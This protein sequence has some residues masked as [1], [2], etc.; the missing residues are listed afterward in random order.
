MSLIKNLSLQLSAAWLL[1]HMKRA[2]KAHGLP[3]DL[4]AMIAK[5]R[6]YNPEYAD[7]L[8]RLLYPK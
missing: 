6:R 1:R 4:M 2:R 5:Y 3:T 7:N 8:E